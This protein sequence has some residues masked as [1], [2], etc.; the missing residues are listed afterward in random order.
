LIASFVLT[1][2]VEKAAEA[3]IEVIDTVAEATEKVADEVAEAF[4]GNETLK[5]AASKIKAIADE[6]EEDADK[7]E[8]LIEK[9]SFTFTQF[10]LLQLL[11][12]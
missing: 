8:A 5:Q 10:R 9:V 12:W 4:P 3:A 1:D 7:A 11:C 2:N 6:I